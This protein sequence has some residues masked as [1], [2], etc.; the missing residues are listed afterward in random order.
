MNRYGNVSLVALAVSACLAL[1]GCGGAD[2]V[3]S[4]GEGSFAGGG[5]PTTPTT[6]TTPQ[7]GTPAS[8]CPSGFAN[9]GT[10]ANGTLRNCQLPQKITGN[11]V[12]PMRNGTVYSVSGRVD[13]GDDQG[14]DPNAPI[15]GRAKGVL[16]VEPGVKIF[17]SAGLD[18]IV[19][20]RGSQI[21]AEGTATKPII[22]TSKQS[23]EGQTGA[24]SIGQ[25][26]GLVIL[27]RAP[28]S[29]C[30]GSGATPG[31][32]GCE[33]QVEGTNAFY[34]GSSAQDNSGVMRYMRVQHSGFVIVAN[35]ELNGITM[36]G[37]GSGTT[38]DHIQV[39]NSSDD[40]IEFFGGTVNGKYLV[41]TG[42]D[43]D[44]VDTDV[45]Y[46]GALQFGIIVQRANG[47][48]RAFE[49]SSAGTAPRSNPKFANWTVVGRGGS[50]ND[51][52]VANTS[53]NNVWLNSVVQLTATTAGCVDIDDATTQA[54][55]H[56]V[57]LA[58][59]TPFTNDSNVDATAVAALFNAGTNNSSAFT[60]SLSGTFINGANEAARPSYANIK[61][62]SSFLTD[63]GYIGAVK[64][65]N[66][67]W[68]Q[69][70]TCGLTSGST[71]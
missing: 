49:T 2:S 21:F 5:T 36:A 6:P 23:I 67:T 42:N 25:W 16:T 20:N 50:G 56:S 44:S 53:T 59:G 69:G 12:V 65:A 22:F 64:D 55:F 46:N 13:V 68:W 10:V 8:D 28:I 58:C 33:A 45:G 54:T 15:A 43:D 63:P 34:G 60:A 4:P 18:Y 35:N 61:S 71:C 70:W 41:L 27:G 51:L 47:G 19:V 48:N 26:G 32:S 57:V 31:T 29:N 14:G 9:V 38:F 1:A 37:V 3:A 52:L 40:G 66:D 30:S 7:P 39:H 24:D 17:G 62:F 11:L